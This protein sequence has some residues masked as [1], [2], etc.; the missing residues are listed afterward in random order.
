M[1]K[2]KRLFVSPIDFLGITSM[3][4]DDNGKNLLIVRAI[5]IRLDLKVTHSLISIG[6]HSI[7]LPDFPWSMKH[8]Q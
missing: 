6:L 7:I 8:F 2:L 5:N 1:N 3:D 4:P